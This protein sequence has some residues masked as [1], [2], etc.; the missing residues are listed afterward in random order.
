M[1]PAERSLRSRLGGLTT[2]ARHDPRDYTASARLAWKSS[3]HEECRAC[4][5][6]PPIPAD[7]PAAERERRRAARLSAHYTRMA[8]RSVRSRSKKAGP[9]RETG[10]ASE[11]R[12]VRVERPTAA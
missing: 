6:Q 10:P 11:V 8:L 5:S 1:T 2:A 12:R 7:L 3:D 9:D 4:G